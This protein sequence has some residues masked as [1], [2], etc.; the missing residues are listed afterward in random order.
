MIISVIKQN[1]NNSVI[2]YEDSQDMIW[3]CSFTQDDMLSHI[4]LLFDGF[5]YSS[6]IENM[7]CKIYRSEI[8]EISIRKY[9]DLVLMISENII[10]A[11]QVCDEFEAYVEKWDFLLLKNKIEVD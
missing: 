9:E 7:F 6:C 10:K 1:I 3:S 8:I 4:R 2:D 11:P 5:S